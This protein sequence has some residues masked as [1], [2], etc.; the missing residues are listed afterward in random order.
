MQKTQIHGC[1]QHE[2]LFYPGTS[3]LAALELQAMALQALARMG[4]SV[5]GI[6]PQESN[7]KAAVAHARGD[8]LVAA[9]SRYLACTAEE[10]AGS[11][12]ASM[13]AC[14]FVYPCIKCI[15]TNPN[16]SVMSCKC[17]Q[18]LGSCRCTGFTVVF[19]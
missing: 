15:L 10:L 11:G 4:A 14:T 1:L 2:L 19:S 9:R 12:M 16:T 6:E 5:T 7:I 8:P 17:N 3:R 18:L 13:Q